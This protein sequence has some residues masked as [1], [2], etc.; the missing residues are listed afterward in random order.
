MGVNYFLVVTAVLVTAVI[1]FLAWQVFT[2]HFASQAADAQVFCPIVQTPYHRGGEQ[3]YLD[4]HPGGLLAHPHRLLGIAPI[5]G[6]G[7]RRWRHTDGGWIHRL[8]PGLSYCYGLYQEDIWFALFCTQAV[9]SCVVIP[10]A[11]FY[12]EVPLSPHA[13]EQS[14]VTILTHSCRISMKSTSIPKGRFP[15]SRVHATARCGSLICATG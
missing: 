13:R 1:T 7:E 3:C 11:I 9:I 2:L 5:H 10:W 4:A 12:Y 15:S 6:S 8:Q 14:T